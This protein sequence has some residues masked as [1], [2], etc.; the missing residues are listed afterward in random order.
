MREMV[1]P[2]SKNEEAEISG[3]KEEKRAERRKQNVKESKR[4]DTKTTAPVA[5]PFLEAT[6]LQLG[7]ERY[8]D[9][10]E[11]AKAV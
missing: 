2:E 1:Y 3:Q 5:F 9:A 7:A 4:S 10:G 6:L 11:G 8:F